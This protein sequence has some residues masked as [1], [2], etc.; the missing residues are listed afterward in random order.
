MNV[1]KSDGADKKENKHHGGHHRW[2]EG[3]PKNQGSAR[4]GL[5][6]FA[7]MS[8]EEFQTKLLDPHMS[9]RLNAKQPSAK[10]EEDSSMNSNT[11]VRRKRAIAAADLPTKVDWRQKGIITPVKHQKSCGACWAFSTVETVES[12]Q[13]LQKGVL[14]PLSVQQVCH[15]WVD[16][17]VL[18]IIQMP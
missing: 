9:S 3:L 12:M 15:E 16:C 13:A 8:P 10:A 6:K 2:R 14:T 7:D 18:W 5:T 4:W 17:C 11:V 1:L